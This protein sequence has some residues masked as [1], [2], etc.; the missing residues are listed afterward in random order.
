M[1]QAPLMLSPAPRSLPE[2]YAVPQ[3]VRHL[4]AVPSAPQLSIDDIA[5]A[6]PT[7]TAAGPQLP[8]TGRFSR[9]FFTAVAEAMVG[10][11]SVD[12]LGPHLALPVAQWLR[13]LTPRHRAPAGT[14]TPRVRAV[15]VCR[16]DGSVLEATAV[17]Q[18]GPHVRAMNARFVG[19]DEHW[20]C[21]QLQ[22][23]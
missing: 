22:L 4:H 19:A 16:P 17:I 1:S 10:R 13:G 21:V 6:A 23:I 3:P 8:D 14:A 9:R 12:Q 15:H 11:R 18:H 5:P 20:R 7:R 2:A